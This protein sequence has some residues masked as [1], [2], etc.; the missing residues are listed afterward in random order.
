MSYSATP[1]KFQ[2]KHNCERKTYPPKAI[3]RLL[4]DVPANSLSGNPLEV[5]L[6][7]QRPYWRGIPGSLAANVQKPT[8]LSVG[9]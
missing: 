2:G 1:K 5:D 4:Q 8:Q 3:G 9:S 7:T 6:N